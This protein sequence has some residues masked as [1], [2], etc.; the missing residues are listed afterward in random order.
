MRYWLGILFLL[1]TVLAEAQNGSIAFVSGNWA[2]VLAQAKKEHRSIF[3]YAGSPSCH[4]CVPMETEVFPVPVVSSYYSSTFLSH[5]INVDEG[6]GTILAKRYDIKRLPS[7]LYFDADGKLLHMSNG[8]KSPAAFVQDGKDAFDPRKAFFTLKERY[9]KGD[10]SPDFLYT[11]GTAPALT[12]KNTLFE[13]VN[14]AYFQ[15]LKP[16]TLT[17]DKNQ[18]YIFGTYT[19]FNAPATQYFLTHASSFVPKFGKAEVS[20]KIRYIVGRAAGE[21]GERND[22]SALKS[23]QQAIARTKVTDAPQW[24]ELAY[25]QYLLGKQQRDWL[26]YTNAVQAYGKQYAAQ[27]NFTLYEATAY[28]TAFVEDKKILAQADPIIKQALAAEPSYLNLCTRAKLLHKIG[29]KQEALLVVNEALAKAA[30][31]Q[32]NS[33][34]A[35]ELLSEINK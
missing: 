11:F 34:E 9:D 19:S 33:T 8:F 21:I 6:E 12:D 1:S 31:D 27:D 7:Y 22:L 13:E 23:L 32:R 26:A 15:T 24:K 20:K 14:G 2:D 18:E 28:V 16:E 25:I 35:T 30:K 4:Y 3:L 10:R 5:K 17:S 29:N